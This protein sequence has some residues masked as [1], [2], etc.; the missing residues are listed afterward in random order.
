MKRIALLI[1]WSLKAW[2]ILASAIIG[3]L[4]YYVVSNYN[5]DVPEVNKT[6]SLILQITG[7][8]LIVYSIDSNIGIVSN[9]SIV[10]LAWR[11]LISIPIFSKSVVINAGTAELKM[12]GVSVKAR[13]GFVST[14]TIEGKIENLQQ[15]INWIKEDLNDEVKNIKN[16]HAKSEK[17]LITKINKLATLVNE[18]DIK[19]N[20]VSLGGINIQLFG[21]LL[22]IHG[23][24]SRGFNSEVQQLG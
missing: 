11:W 15:Q 18:T 21:I 13:G 4:H 12:Q 3:Y 5:V 24:I 20:K 22:M 19:L 7:G 9:K 10:G 2:P 16:F 6:S 1:N 8:L 23:S 17:T 14:D